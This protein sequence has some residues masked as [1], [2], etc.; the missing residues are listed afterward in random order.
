MR[1]NRFFSTLHLLLKREGR[2]GFATKIGRNRSAIA[3]STAVPQFSV[4]PTGKSLTQTRRKKFV[5]TTRLSFSYR[6]G[7]D[8]AKR[9]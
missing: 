4:E 5:K 6:K 3:V 8:Q 7:P 2:A 1:N 9:N